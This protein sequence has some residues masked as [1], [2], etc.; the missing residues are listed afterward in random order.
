MSDSLSFLLEN[1]MSAEQI[2]DQLARGIPMEEIV[3]GAERALANGESL[4]PDVPPG[5]F[6]GSVGFVGHPLPE[7]D[8]NGFSE[9]CEF[10]GPDLS[11][12]PPFPVDEFSIDLIN[13]AVLASDN[14][15]VSMDMP[16]ASILTVLAIC[17]Q[18]KFKVNP[19]PGWIEPVNLYTV[20]VALPSERKS[21]TIALSMEP[22]YEYQAEENERRRPLVE[23]YMAK[24]DMLEGRIVSMKKAAISGR[25]AKGG[26]E[27]TVDDIMTLHRELE[28]LEKGAV[29][30]LS[31]TADDITMEALASKM[32][33][34]GER[35]ALVS[36]EGGIFNVLSGL[37][38]GGIG[39]IELIL[40]SY[41]GDHVEVDR[42]GRESE[43]L[44]H[45]SLSV[46]LMVQPRVLE[47]TMNN[48]EFAG[49]GLNARFLYSIPVSPVGGRA[50]DTMEIPQEVKKAYHDL[51]YR[52]LS[53]PD[54]GEPRIIKLTDEARDELRKI[55]YEIEPRLRGDLEPLGDW[56][57]KYLGTV[58]R[59][60]GLLHICDH[61]EKAAD[62]LM[63]AETVRRASKIGQYF[64]AHAKVAYQM[65]GRADDQATKDAKYI[66]SRIDS[67]GE[68]EI[69]KRDLF[70]LCQDRVGMETVDKLDPGL[71]VLVKRG[72][73]KIESSPAG[74][75]RQNG[76]N[77]R[78]GGRPRS[79]MIYVNPKYMK[80]KE[81]K[82]EQHN[83]C[84]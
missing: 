73:I 82:H 17:A 77:P 50:F 18:G 14:L 1:G 44:A 58:V 2:Q 68:T 16:S 57:G 28:D 76:Q 42:K 70:R 64:L 38:T 5:G 13:F 4:A 80:L 40:K 55:H 11:K 59:I 3:A 48:I 6:G 45:P 69:R 79:P 22:V 41:S 36:S 83:Q 31:L 26:P 54:T 74:Q 15:Q 60:A 37:Y 81:E 33:A 9:F 32:A 35:M 61:V 72:Y 46:L 51:I 65:S 7:I 34:N 43:H 66:I 12:N 67:T 24:H 47:A 75:N 52:L 10:C 20:I 21:P 25:K 39:N 23:E 78:K 71:N 8:E 62:V 56:A 29:N 53:I 84:G 30:Y 63:P 27:P 19:K 49:R